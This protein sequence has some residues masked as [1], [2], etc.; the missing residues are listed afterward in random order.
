MARIDYFNDPSAP[1]ANSVVPS[2]TAAIRNGAGDVL[3]IHKVDNDLWALPGGGHDA[4]EY[5]TDT[6]VREVQ[7][8]TGLDVEV[9]RLVGTYTNPAHVM[10]YDDGEVRQQFS[11]CFECRWIGG[12]PR[13]DGSETKEVRWVAPADL[14]GLNI[15]PSMRLRIDH[16]LDSARTSPYLG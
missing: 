1:P 12:E 14:D 10:A 6:V 3:L 4:G 7:E 13:E 5:L 11:L 8:E 9:V 16:A 2:V 15:H